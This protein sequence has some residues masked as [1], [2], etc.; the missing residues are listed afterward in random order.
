MLIRNFYFTRRAME[1]VPVLMGNIVS[2]DCSISV[3]VSRE[4]T[5][6]FT[7][8]REE[9]ILFIVSEYFSADP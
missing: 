5:K 9:K 3:T 1:R 8:K 7:V 6:N 2:R 4:N